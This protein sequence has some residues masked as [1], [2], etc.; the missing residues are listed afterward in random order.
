MSPDFRQRARV[1]LGFV[2]FV[3]V[4]GISGFVSVVSVW[5][6]CDSGLQ[7]MGTIG[8]RAFAVGL[9][10]GL[11][12]LYK[13]RWVLVFP[14]IQRRPFFSFKMGIPSAIAQAFKLSSASYL[15][16]AALSIFLPYEYRSQV[17]TGKF[18]VEQIIFYIGCFVV[19]LC[20]EL[21]HHL[22]QVLHTK[23]FTFAPPK[24]S[25]AAETNPSEPLLAA[26]EQSSPKSLLQYLAYLD[27][28]MVCESNVDTW[29]R[30]AF[31][32]ETGET[33]KKVVSVCLRPLEQ[34]TLRLGEGL[35]SCLADNPIQ[36]H[37]QLRSPTDRIAYSRL[38]EP[39]YD[40]QL[41][42]WCARI[43]ASLTVGSHREDRFGV[44][45]L[46]GS[47]ASVM[48]TL[49]SCLLAVETSMGKKT[50]L[51]PPQFLMGPA[52]IKWSTVSTGRRDIAVGVIGKRKDSV[53]YSK[54]YSMADIV[55]TS[56]YCIVSAFQDEMLSSS[57]TG[58][59][60]KDWITT[61]KPLYGTHDLLLQ[62][63]RLFLDFR[64]S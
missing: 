59:L 17:T 47:N 16:S 30:A 31:F 7:P 42:A 4:C 15:I 1:S 34:L 28:R 9:C 55:K 40:I 44:A 41:C 12:Y 21:S 56:I 38:Y 36:L 25:A 29:R 39:F 61:S 35:E 52:G 10:F 43:V 54:A 33:Y 50:N 37:H 13:K 8:F 22:H 14:I 27:L 48:S 24:G 5:W 11:Y 53:Q 23:R 49:V 58:L 19:F 63:L 62:K 60:E 46:S 51:Q 18:I 2:L 45:Q 64:A 32:E 20:W 6:S 3:S 57:K 26:L